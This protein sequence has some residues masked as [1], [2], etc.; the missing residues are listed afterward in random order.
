MNVRLSPFKSKA[1]PNLKPT[2]VFNPICWVKVFNP[3]LDKNNPISSKST[4]TQRMGYEN[5]PAFF[6]V[7]ACHA[8]SLI[9]AQVLHSTIQRNVPQSNVTGP[10]KSNVVTVF[11]N[12]YEESKYHSCAWSSACPPACPTDSSS[13]FCSKNSICHWQKTLT[14]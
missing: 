4:A 13:N 6:S 12:L 1:R 7:R 2:D 5:N 8:N 10:N 11:G 14:H 3:T 9:T